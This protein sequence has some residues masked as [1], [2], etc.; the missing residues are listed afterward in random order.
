MAEPDDLCQGVFGIDLFLLLARLPAF[1][2]DVAA[3]HGLHPHPGAFRAVFHGKEVQGV[4]M[5]QIGRILLGKYN[6]CGCGLQNLPQ[7]PIRAVTHA[8]LGQRTIEYDPEGLCVGM[9]S[10]ENTGCP[11]GPHGMRRGRP[12]AD[13]IDFTDGTHFDRLRN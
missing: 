6:F 10:F 13:F 3:A 11:F 1:D 5:L 2:H 4:G 7:H 9:L 8:G 12:L